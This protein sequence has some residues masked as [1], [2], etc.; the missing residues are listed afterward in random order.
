MLLIKLMAVQLV[1]LA[2]EIVCELVKNITIEDAKN[3]TQQDIIDKVGNL[4]RAK[5]HCIIYAKQA[6]DDVIKKIVI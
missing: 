2:F 1:F 4:P 5:K 3:I 6:L